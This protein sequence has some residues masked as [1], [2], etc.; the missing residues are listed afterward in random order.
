LLIY[1]DSRRYNRSWRSVRRRR[2]YYVVVAEERK[3]RMHIS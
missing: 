1:V 3:N 2:R